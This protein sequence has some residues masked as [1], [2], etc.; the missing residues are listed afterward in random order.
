[1]SVD[2]RNFFTPPDGMRCNAIAGKGVWSNPDGQ[3]RR[4]KLPGFDF[5]TQ[6]LKAAERRAKNAAMDVSRVATKED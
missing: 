6:H 2:K 5:C 4:N 1:M 3:C